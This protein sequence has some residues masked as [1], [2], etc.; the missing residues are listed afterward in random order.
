LSFSLS[1]F[2]IEDN[3]K[4]GFLVHDPGKSDLSNFSGTT[5]LG[6]RAANKNA[7]GDTKEQLKP[8][9]EMVDQGVKVYRRSCTGW[10]GARRACSKTPV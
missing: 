4:V 5:T 7:Y 8:G 6:K 2:N 1:S 9:K 3:V 10:Q